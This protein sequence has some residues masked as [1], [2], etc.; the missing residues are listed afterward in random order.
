[1]VMV[2][3]IVYW[4]GQGMA[5]RLTGGVPSAAFIVRDVT[6]FVLM[7]GVDQENSMISRA[8][9]SAREASLS[10]ASE[11]ATD[12]SLGGNLSPDQIAMFNEALEAFGLQPL[13]DPTCLPNSVF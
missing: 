4:I 9:L 1:M 3:Y 8:Q 12:A 10:R 7:K 11:T 5:S 2:R 6:G 13:Q